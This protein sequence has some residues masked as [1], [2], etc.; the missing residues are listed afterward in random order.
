MQ[1]AEHPHCRLS[2]AHPSSWDRGH[3][4]DRAYSKTCQLTRS[5]KPDSEPATCSPL[6]RQ[7]GKLRR[8]GGST[9]N[10]RLCCSLTGEASD[11]GFSPTWR[12]KAK[13]RPRQET[14]ARDR[15]FEEAL[16]SLRKG[17]R[18]TLVIDQSLEGGRVTG[19]GRWGTELNPHAP[20]GRTAALNPRVRKRR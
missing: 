7:P 6:F 5:H 15:G 19:E 13:T 1:S 9:G 2:C 11:Q 20:G 14:S 18:N 12:L 3:K 16:V 4:T 17:R 8:S 10:E